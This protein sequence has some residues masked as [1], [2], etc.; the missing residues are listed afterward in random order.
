MERVELSDMEPYPLSNSIRMQL[1]APPVVHDSISPEE[2]LLRSVRRCKEPRTAKR[3]LIGI[4]LWIAASIGN[5]VGCATAL[6]LW[7]ASSGP[8][9]R[10]AIVLMVLCVGVF[11]SV[12]L[13]YGAAG[14]LADLSPTI[15]Y[16][17]AKVE[18]QKR[19]L[20]NSID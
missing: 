18:Q 14:T 17:R 10:I 5:V 15:R 7:S 2:S 16:H 3:R 11:A 8:I 12:V 4:V 6:Y 19:R 13:V 9:D 1:E 20:N